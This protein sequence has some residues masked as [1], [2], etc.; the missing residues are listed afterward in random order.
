MNV[1]SA[2]GNIDNALLDTELRASLGEPGAPQH[3]YTSG[4][5]GEHTVYF[6]DSVDSGAV[7]STLDAHLAGAVLRAAKALQAQLEAVVQSYMDSQ[8]KARGYDDLRASIS[9]RGDANV[10]WAH[11]ADVFFAWRSS[12]WTTCLSVMNDVQAGKRVVPTEA[13]LIALLPA[14]VF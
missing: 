3:W 4:A 5:K 8:A 10:T 2:R 1:L 7:Q 6:D 12:V 13:E 9:Y 11:E 14:L